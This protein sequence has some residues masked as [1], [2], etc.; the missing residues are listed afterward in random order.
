MPRNVFIS[1]DAVTLLEPSPEAV[2]AT[3]E[4]IK[5]LAEAEAKACAE[6]A[7][8][9]QE[10]LGPGWK[11]YRRPDPDKLAREKHPGKPRGWL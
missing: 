1:A 10:H 3:D 8:R 11:P 9:H 5:E 7:A 4:A 2:K 6:R